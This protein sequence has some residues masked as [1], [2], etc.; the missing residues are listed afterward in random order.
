MLY[1]LENREKK[2][3]DL[4]QLRMSELGLKHDIRILDFDEGTVEAIIERP[5]V[6]ITHPVRDDHGAC[7][8]TALKVLYAP[9]VITLETEGLMD[10]DDELTVKIRIGENQYDKSLVDYYFFWGPRPCRIFADRLI[11]SGKVTDFNRVKWCGYIMYDLDIVRHQESYRLFSKQY[12]AREQGFDKAV[13][14]LTGFNAVD[15]SDEEEINRELDSYIMMSSFSIDEDGNPDKE[16]LQH[17][18]ENIIKSARFRDAYLELIR[19][20]AVR[21]KNTL[22]WVKMHPMEIGGKNTV[23]Y[24]E[25]LRGLDNVEII[26]ED[27]PVGVLFDNV[28]V[29]VHYGSTAGLEAT[30][31]KTPTI[32]ISGDCD[33]NADLYEST[34]KINME[35]EENILD[36][37]SSDI[38][39]VEKK[40]TVKF[41]SDNFGIDVN[42]SNHPI[43]TLIDIVNSK[44][45]G[46][47]IRKRNNTML[48]NNKY[49]KL[50]FR[51]ALKEAWIRLKKR[52]IMEAMKLGIGTIRM[53]I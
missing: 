26:S 21:S 20:Y 17:A 10:F 53:W 4:I 39:Y 50:Y 19:D 49:M 15:A 37:L 36:L 6:I 52:N 35:D 46:Q 11:K 7:R 13:L 8:M 48:Y 22:V 42:Q 31:Y 43:D 32:A 40:S 34:Y 23:R 5:D 18:R 33:S 3:F 9:V 24:R 12:K 38:S 25:M 41:I 2:I 1:H 16:E 27:V 44:D 45:R 29:M 51:S 28:D 14:F 47:K 30:I